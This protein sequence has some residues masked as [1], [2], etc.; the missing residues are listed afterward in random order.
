MSLNLKMKGRY[1]QIVLGIQRKSLER[2]VGKEGIQ[3]LS[4]MSGSKVVQTLGISTP[5]SLGFAQ[6]WYKVEFV[7]KRVTIS[8]DHRTDIQEKVVASRWDCHHEYRKVIV[9]SGSKVHV[10]SENDIIRVE[11]SNSIIFDWHIIHSCS[12]QCL[13]TVFF[14]SQHRSF[15]RARWQHP[16]ICMAQG[17]IEQ[18]HLL[19][20][21]AFD[22][23][24]C[25]SWWRSLIRS[26]LK[27]C[28][29]SCARSRPSRESMRILWSGWLWI[30]TKVWLHW[31]RISTSLYRRWWNSW[32]KWQRSF[33]TEYN[34]VFWSKS[35]TATFISR[36][37]STTTW[38]HC[39][40]EPRFDKRDKKHWERKGW[41]SDDDRRN[42]C[43]QRWIVEGKRM[44]CECSG[45]RDLHRI[46]CYVPVCSMS[47]RFAAYVGMLHQ[48]GWN[49]AECYWCALSERDVW[50]RSPRIASQWDCW[51]L[52]TVDGGIE[53]RFADSWDVGR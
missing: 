33:P 10:I 25:L 39:G 4:R 12:V 40:K 19:Y 51:Y 20:T 22:I 47:F 1:P 15:A 24:Q 27:R 53:S 49:I 13:S 9:D 7:S 50:Q 48:I 42:D 18:G 21:C 34:C 43:R 16:C 35:V 32:S 11:E 6:A 38:R 28:H 29:L 3:M 2:R 5:E 45:Q 36:Q 17:H 52:E 26:L 46:W 14:F 30:H 37:I 41:K 44:W 23:I 31:N 8:S